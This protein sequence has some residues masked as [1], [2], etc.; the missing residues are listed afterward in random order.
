[1]AEN[2]DVAQAEAQPAD[3]SVLDHLQMRDEEGQIR[4]EFVDEITRAIEAADRPLL[5]EVVAEL[6]EADLG[7]LI[8]ALEPDNRVKLVELTGTDFDFSAL[9][10]VDDAVREEILEELE[11]ETVAEGV[12]ELESDDAVEL[13]EGLDEEDQEEILEKLPPSERD[14][15]ERSL[16]Y[17]ENSAGRRM[18]SEFIAVP[19]DWT[20]GQAIDYMRDTPNLPGRFYE[21]YAVDF[22]QHWQG[23]VALDALLRSRRPVPLAD[24][25]DE[26]RRRVSVMDDQEEVAR[27]FGKYN[28]VA[29]PVLDTESRLVGVI[30]IDD[31]VDV[32]EE[33]AAEDLK[34]LGGVTSDEELS[35]SVWTIARGRFNWLLVN[36]ATAFLASSVLGLFEGELEK[37]VALAVLA[38][39]VASQGGN[40]ATQT[41]TV[42]VR[43]L[44]TRELGASNVWRVVMREIL[45]GFVNGIGFAIITGIA[46][47]AW[48]RIP[49]L[50]VVIGLA[51]IC[52][53]VAGALGGILIP[54]LLERVR[55]DPA[56]ASGTF[57]TT[58]TDVVGFFSFLGI[59]TLWFGLR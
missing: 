4:H 50:G 32:I 13:L 27:L 38:P 46:A 43:A 59:A 7:D 28:L 18:Q 29:A 25:I 41:M 54:I 12:R 36:L 47:V 58:I 21:I 34:A 8:G 15:L 35:D 10:E 53:L 42:A 57:V 55:A 14:A 20:V 31:V 24:L 48:F 3:R 19:P 49:G 39:I 17:P 1:M 52:N 44:A 40:A 56:V 30:T 16:L 23:A 2:I 11:P 37:M 33:E 6:H 9:N 22:A 5:C 26:D 51:I 45:V